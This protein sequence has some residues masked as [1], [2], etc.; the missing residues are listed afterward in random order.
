MPALISLP[1][2]G[3]VLPPQVKRIVSFSFGTISTELY[4]PPFSIPDIS[5]SLSISNDISEL[6]PTSSVALIVYLPVVLKVIS[7]CLTLSL[8]MLTVSAFLILIVTSRLPIFS[9]S[10][11]ISGGVLSISNLNSFKK[12]SELYSFTKYIPSFSIFVPLKY[13]VVFI[14]VVIVA[15]ASPW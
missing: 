10:P 3:T 5:T 9:Y 6:L 14:P 12:P 8:L 13:S 11:I 2:L 7:V 1:S 15:F 4:I